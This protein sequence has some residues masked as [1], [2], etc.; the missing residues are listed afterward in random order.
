MVAELAVL[1]TS[2]TAAADRQR[3]ARQAVLRPRDDRRAD[4]RGR[5][6]LSVD[7]RRAR[8]NL[9]ARR[10]DAASEQHGLTRRHTDLIETRASDSATRSVKVPAVAQP[11][12]AWIGIG[13]AQAAP[14]R[15]RSHSQN[16][17]GLNRQWSADDSASKLSEGVSTVAAS[18]VRNR[19]ARW[20]RSQSMRVHA[21]AQHPFVVR[22][23]FAVREQ[24]AMPVRASSIAQAQKMRLRDR[25][26]A[27][28]VQHADSAKSRTRSG[29]SSQ[30][31]PGQTHLI[32]LDVTRPS[33]AGSAS[34]LL[35]KPG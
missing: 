24:A 1:K 21:R 2:W 19:A 11:L 29:P 4:M 33:E 12:H 16:A 6:R 18:A 17:P 32:S 23:G 3:K 34:A 22:I 31:T 26:S 9:V 7:Q 10:R 5:E 27:C 13:N 8:D 20:A 35:G 15:K 14:C 25:H 30:V 28:T